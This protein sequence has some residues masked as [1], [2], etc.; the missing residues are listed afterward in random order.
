MPDSVIGKVDALLG[1]F[2]DDDDQ[3]LGLSD[4]ARRAGVAKTTVHRLATELVALGYLERSGTRLR[5]GSRLFE[6]GQRVPRP[7][8][9]RE[10]ARPFME[11]LLVAT[12]ET[13]HLAVRDG[14]EVL[15]LEKLAGRHRVAAPS[16]VAGRMPMHCTATGKAILAFSPPEVQSQVLDAALARRTP[17]TI[18]DPRALRAELRRVAHEGLAV[19]VEE[20]RM[21][22]ASVAAPFFSSTGDV[23]GALAVTGPTTRVDPASLAPIVRTAT[24]GLTRMLAQRD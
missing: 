19:E 20:T 21:A 9:L 7:A 14:G 3:E 22:H 17:F 1:A 8:V 11:D 12:H 24:R 16:R 13:I 18:T 23:L 10:A 2:V 4:L 15:Y 6:L 5:L